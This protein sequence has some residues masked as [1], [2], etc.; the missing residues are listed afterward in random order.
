M[1]S[2]LVYSYMF[3]CDSVIFI[4]HMRK[5]INNIITSTI[6]EKSYCSFGF[7]PVAA[8]VV[9]SNKEYLTICGMANMKQ[10]ARN[11]L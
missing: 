10:C 9:E 11:N 5:T 3:P 2:H 6:F 7:F 1:S 8:V 4:I